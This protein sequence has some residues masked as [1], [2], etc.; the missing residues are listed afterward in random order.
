MR[1]TTGSF[2]RHSTTLTQAGRCAIRNRLASG[3]PSRWQRMTRLTP[4]W[5]AMATTCVSSSST[6]SRQHGSTRAAR[7]AKLS[8]PRRAEIDDVAPARGVCRPAAARR[9]RAA[10]DP[11]NRPCRSR[12]APDGR[13]SG[14]RIRSPTAPL[15]AATAK[16]RCN[17]SRLDVTRGRRRA[18]ELA[19]LRFARRAHRRVGGAE[20]ALFGVVVD[21]AVTDQQRC[22]HGAASLIVSRRLARD[23]NA[24]TSANAASTRRAPARSA[25][26]TTG[27]SASR[28][29]TAASVA[30]TR[31]GAGAAID[32]VSVA[33]APLSTTAAKS[34]TASSANSASSSRGRVSSPPLASGAPAPTRPAKPSSRSQRR[35]ARTGRLD[36]PREVAGAVAQQRRAAPPQGRN[37]D[38][39]DR[40]GRR[41]RAAGGIDDFDQQLVL[42]QM[43][44]AMEGAIDRAAV[45][46]LGHA[47]VA[48]DFGAPGRRQR[49]AGRPPVAG[50]TTSTS[51]SS[52]RRWQPQWKAQSTAP[53]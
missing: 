35:S 7:S 27:S 46:G 15:S 3:A 6:M 18:D 37:D 39:A 21:R 50:S 52:S 13:G 23:E 53:P 20:E 32:S 16:D 24:A 47:P 36:Q 17:R 22:A 5:P 38:F 25:A 9:F 19:D 51:S 42:A 30:A 11:A 41:R 4:A 10:T 26:P 34:L 33:G 44:T 43:A 49:G 48:E 29:R 14:W 45:A 31:S 40:A 2:F 12:A 1:V 28:A 8:P